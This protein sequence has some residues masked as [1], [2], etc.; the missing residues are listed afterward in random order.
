MEINVA[1][2]FPAP[3]A[4][5]SS[6]SRDRCGTDRDGKSLIMRVMAGLRVAGHRPARWS[7][8]RGPRWLRRVA[9]AV[10]EMA[11]HTKVW[12]AAAGVM[13]AAGGW[14]GRTAA[15]GVTSMAVAQVL[16][17]AVAKPLYRRRRPPREWVP[18]EDLQNRPDSFSFPSGH[19]AAAFAF[20]GAV[21]PVWPAVG[22]ACAVSAVPVS[23]ERVHSGAHYPSDVAAGGA[24][25]LAAAPLVPAAPRL[26]RRRVRWRAVVRRCR[27][28]R[29]RDQ[30]VEG[31]CRSVAPHGHPVAKRACRKR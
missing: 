24:L 12:W 28:T 26:L 2:P 1:G 31:D 23:A 4:G 3:G 10:E 20:A 13:A 17:N 27:G 6:R 21:T 29:T 22:A 25:G 30:T 14:R 8:A 11:E 5:A 9:P 15:A 7:I 16:S 19:T 18:A